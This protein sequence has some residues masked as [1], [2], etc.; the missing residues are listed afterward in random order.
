MG[1]VDT[2]QTLR[3][4]IRLSPVLFRELERMAEERSEG[5]SRFSVAQLVE[6]IAENVA[7]ERRSETFEGRR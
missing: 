2:G 3:V 5:E 4:E 6:Q 1:E 7:A